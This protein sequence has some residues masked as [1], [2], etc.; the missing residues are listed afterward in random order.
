M[1]TFLIVDDSKMINNGLATRLTEA[2][3]NVTQVFTLA[4]AISAVRE[5]EFDYILLDLILPDGDGEMLLPFVQHK[6]SKIIVLTTD[7]DS[8]RRDKIFNFGIVDYIIKDRVFS[9][10]VGAIEELYEKIESNNK[11]TVLVVDDS[12]FIR[13]HIAQMLEKR[14]INIIQAKN[15]KE[16][17]S[18]L[19]SRRQIDMAIVDLEMPEM[20]G[21]TLVGKMKKNIS[22]MNIP[23]MILTGSNDA[24]IVAKVIKSGVWDFSKKPYVVEELLLKVDNI[25]DPKGRIL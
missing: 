15:G 21:L 19:L 7:R 3:H 16:A 20:D 25:L 1:S 8:F 17:L 2:S 10:I 18:V 14:G 24:N 4:D 6:R 12:N 5:N 11:Y 13:K 9:E 23:V 22:M